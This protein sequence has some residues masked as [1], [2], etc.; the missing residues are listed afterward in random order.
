MFWWKK[1]N[2]T[3]LTHYSS[4]QLKGCSSTRCKGLTFICVLRY[5]VLVIQGRIVQVAD[6][7]EGQKGRLSPWDILDV[8]TRQGLCNGRT[9]EVF[10][11][12]KSCCCMDWGVWPA[13]AEKTF[14]GQIEANLKSR[15]LKTE[16]SWHS[17]PIRS[18]LCSEFHCLHCQIYCIVF[19]RDT[20]MSISA[21]YHMCHGRLGAARIISL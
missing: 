16:I 5:C 15:H 18:M 3:L 17:L 2:S 21:D 10:C 8:W 19:V 7:G 13:S 11:V 12:P 9:T 6:T 1:F 14:G 20:H 4:V